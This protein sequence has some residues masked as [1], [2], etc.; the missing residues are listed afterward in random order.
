MT[1]APCEAPILDPELECVL[2]DA[3]QLCRDMMNEV[4]ARELVS[5]CDVVDW[6]LD[7]QSKMT[8]ALSFYASN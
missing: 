3:L 5:S 2:Q 8:Q 4:S 6:A 7:M 1:T